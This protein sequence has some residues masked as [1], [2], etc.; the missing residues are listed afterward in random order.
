MKEKHAPYLHISPTR[1]KAVLMI[2]GICSTPR[3]FDFLVSS[4][5][6][7][8]TV[9]ALLLEGHGGT[10]KDFTNASMKK[11]RA[12]V[13]NA[14][15]ALEADHREIYIV[16]YSMGTLLALEALEA[17]PKIKGL[18]LLNPPFRPWV[19]WEMAKR[20]YRFAKGRVDWEQPHETACQE[21]IGVE[22]TSTLV[23]YAGWIPRFLELLL[24]CR[25]A[26]RRKNPISVPCKVFLGV[27]DELVSLRSEKYPTAQE[28]VEIRIS[29]EAGHFYYSDS[30]K[31]WMIEALK[32]FT[33]S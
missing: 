27:K 4:L 9:H 8:V 10:V 14:L 3:H 26:R 32:D 16:G 31:A 17:H 28:N 24:L 11:W 20:S 19:R 15:T 21:S 22:L 25:R 12:D 7:E 6:G 29:H 18:L 2:H 1:E 30:D 23:K 33:A 13:E 5:P